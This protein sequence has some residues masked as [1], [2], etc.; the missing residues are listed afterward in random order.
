MI[1]KKTLK[2]KKIFS[3]SSDELTRKDKDLLQKWLVGSLY[4]I[5]NKNPPLRLD[6]T[7]LEIV[8]LK[9]I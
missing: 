5:D 8:N 7:P 4:V 1:I 6:Y 2:E 3:K 9:D